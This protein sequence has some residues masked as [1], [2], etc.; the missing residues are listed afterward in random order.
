MTWPSKAA[1]YLGKETA[2]KYR[3][4]WT[5]VQQVE[6]DCSTNL[7]PLMV[8]KAELL[9][10]NLKLS[11]TY[12]VHARVGQSGNNPV[13]ENPNLGGRLSLVRMLGP[14]WVGEPQ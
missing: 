5:F 11:A 9:E 6:A 8:K 10:F 4:T 12:L 3:K 7:E 13:R 1:P 2:L 14:W